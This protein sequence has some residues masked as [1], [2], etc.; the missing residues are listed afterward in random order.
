MR[1]LQF[2]F[3]Y[4]GLSLERHYSFVE[5]SEDGDFDIKFSPCKEIQKGF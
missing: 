1:A 4:Y 3:I 5:L 2:L